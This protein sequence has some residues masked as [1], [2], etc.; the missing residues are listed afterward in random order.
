M[1]FRTPCR[2]GGNG[3]SE[4]VANSVQK[5]RYDIDIRDK[6]GKKVEVRTSIYIYILSAAKKCA[7]YCEKGPSEIENGS[8]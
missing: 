4:K 5:R 3:R 2:W 8:M 7:I 1:Y 6:E